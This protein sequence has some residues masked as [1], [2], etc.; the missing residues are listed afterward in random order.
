MCVCVNLG[1]NIP[2]PLPPQP[3]PG[4]AHPILLMLAAKAVPRTHGPLPPPSLGE[5]TSEMEMKVVQPGLRGW[6]LG[7]SEPCLCGTSRRM[8]PP[9][10]NDCS[11]TVSALCPCRDRPCLL[12]LSPRAE[13]FLW[14]P[15]LYFRKVP[16]Q[17]ARPLP[18][19]L[20]P[21]VLGSCGTFSPLG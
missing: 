3:R 2:T 11:W 16:I 20:H 1:L 13:N 15:D 7:R 10:W 6:G 19:W 17:G 18:L 12:Q 5:G 14:L 8:F 4:T 9:P 21:C